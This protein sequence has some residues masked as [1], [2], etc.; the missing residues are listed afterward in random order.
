M[1]TEAD[2]EHKFYS[3]QP[4]QTPQKPYGGAIARI[5]V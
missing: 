4:S 5:D 3:P 2:T 1:A